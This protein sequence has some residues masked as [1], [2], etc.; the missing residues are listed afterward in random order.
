MEHHMVSRF[1]NFSLLLLLCTAYLTWAD[2]PIRGFVVDASSAETLPAANV[3]IEGTHR[4]TSTN[5]DGYF[6]I[7]HL[8][9]G[10]YTLHISHIG[11]HTTI[12][13]VIVSD[14]LMDPVTFELI[15][16]VIELEE[17]E[18]AVEK[19]DVR[20][21]PTVSSVPIDA[22]TL[23]RVP[24]LAVES[25]VLRAVQ[26]IPGVKTS[27]ELSSSIYVRGGSPDQTLILL[28][29]NVIYNPNHL[30]G[31]FSTFNADVTKRVNLMKGGFPAEYGG[32]SGS[33]LEIVTNEGNRK[34]FAGQ[35]SMGLVS[36]RMAL[37]GPLPWR[38]GS[39]AISGRRTFVD[40][41]VEFLLAEGIDLDI[42]EYFF[43]D[44]NGKLNLDLS[45]TSTLN[46][47]WYIGDDDLY[48]ESGPE[49]NRTCVNLSWGNRLF[50][51]R[52]RQVLGRN[53]FLSANAALSHYQSKSNEDNNGVMISETD[54]TLYDYL[55]KADVELLGSHT[56]HF[57]TGVA[58]NRY[59]FDWTVRELGVTEA[60]I[61]EAS[62][63][64][65]AY[66]QDSWRISALF[67]M[68]P[69]LRIYYYDIGEY[70]EFD[71]RLACVYHYST[72]MRFKIGGGRYTQFIN[73]LNFGEGMSNYDIW[74]PVDETLGPS[75]ADQIVLGFE[76][77]PM[78]DLEL[79]SETYY[80][81]MTNLVEYNRLHI[82]ETQNASDIFLFGGKGHAYGFELMLHRISGR[83]TGWLGYSL[84]WIERRFEGTYLNDGNWYYPIWDRR[85]DIIAVASYLLN[86][87][88]ELSGSWRFH[89][90]Q[91][92][93]QELGVY[94][95]R[96][97]SY[98][99]DHRILY[100]SLN[101]CRFPSDHRLDIAAAYHHTFWTGHPATVR[102]G[103]Y[104]VY[105]RRSYWRRS[106]DIDKNPVE[107]KDVRLLP[108][109]PMFNY[110]VRF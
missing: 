81:N 57:K 25:D 16:T 108:I 29:H 32:R 79:T 104:N 85:H 107:I 12:I 44:A 99:Y 88:W 45:R 89:T 37:E 51:S 52:Y 50:S 8:E 65:S 11:Y 98:G 64:Y 63:L 78:T 82:N 84:S 90:G 87:R 15:P 33:V 68:Q 42:P 103:I 73:L 80:T 34:E 105:S 72:D 1:I 40:P 27:S 13:T 76:W 31:I 61:D 39:Y 58:V 66:L 56:H 62:N 69:G 55:L 46:T 5:L 77:E 94:P 9:P 38:K 93:T 102:V 35:A 4:G 24:M 95:S 106:V 14:E 22:G 3:I 101:N 41:L 59:H 21:S 71:P 17:A 53:L 67:E 60:D 109:L 100:G 30:F 43:Y 83:L 74:V 91:G 86:D 47:S 10:E 96:Y 28:D 23:R 36:A 6:V 19:R 70:T 20:R 54:N 92:F 18:V 48:V 2:N 97:S 75:R 26:A 110:E 7:D 49:Y